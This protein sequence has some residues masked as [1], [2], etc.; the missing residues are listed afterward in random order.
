L[1]KASGSAILA[2][3][4]AM[5]NQGRDGIAAGT[6][7]GKYEI[8]RLLGSGGM[9]SVYEGLHVELRKR[10]AIKTLHPELA[11]RKTARQRFLREGEAA[12]RVRHPHIVDVTDVDTHDGLP[13]LVMEFLE[14]L[15]LKQHVVQNGA[16]TAA[17]TVDLLLPAIA[18]VA[19][20]HDEG[21]IHRDL[22]PHNIFLAHTRTG[23]VV[24]KVLDFGVSKLMH[25]ASGGSSL[26]GAAAIMGTVA[27]MSPEQ[28]K[29]AKFVD[30]RTDQ[31]ALSLILYEC[32]TGKRP[33]RG[34]NTL[35]VLRQIGDGAIDPP[36]M[37]APS[38]PAEMEAVILK[39]LSVRPDERFPSLYA[40]GKALLPFAGERVRAVWAA[41]FDRQPSEVS[42][43]SRADSGLESNVSEEK[44]AALVSPDE[45]EL[46]VPVGMESM[47]DVSGLSPEASSLGTVELRGAQRAS[48]RLPTAR[49]V[50]PVARES[51]KKTPAAQTP[52]RGTER[53]PAGVTPARGT[54]R[55]PSGMT[56]ARGTDRRPAGTP[57]S[58]RVHAESTLGQSA[59]ELELPQNLPPRPAANKGS[60][61]AAGVGLGLAGAVVA[62]AV[63]VVLARHEDKAPSAPAVGAVVAAPERTLRLDLTVSPRDAEIVLDGAR[64]GRGTLVQEIAASS[65]AHTL[66][67]SAPGY[68]PQ[69]ITFI[70]VPPP[71]SLTLARLPEPMRRKSAP[72]RAPNAPLEPESTAPPPAQE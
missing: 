72:A 24:A 67:V 38:L 9:G 37:Y 48:D 51:S 49:E 26:T 28:A 35:A 68:E 69:T 60:R 58:S 12:S 5:T 30:G 52:P 65:Q 21:V 55:P 57:V 47:P 19:A 3:V 36:R 8:V 4:G 31:Y 66:R 23:E 59:A 18:A 44:L 43:D 53:R 50:V 15:D 20:G 45:P 22:K 62:F 29:G 42:R 33:Y 34:E 16:M 10:V 71:R 61:T 17:A 14:G 70:D 46:P 56:P 6:R 54:E 7:I 13:Y 2:W 11:M 32:V 39:A 64:V 25:A 27:Y 41:T 63:V 40:F 1:L